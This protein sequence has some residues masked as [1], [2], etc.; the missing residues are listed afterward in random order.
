VDETRP[1]T[2]ELQRCQLIKLSAY[3]SRFMV[4]SEWGRSELRSDL[5]VIELSDFCGVKIEFQR[6]RVEKSAQ[7]LQSEF[8]RRV[9]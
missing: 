7:R 5:L 2:P 3:S 9:L 8:L 1:Y 4:C 6:K